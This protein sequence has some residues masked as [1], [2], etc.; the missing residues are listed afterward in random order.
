[1]ILGVDFLDEHALVLDFTNTSVG[2]HPASQAATAAQILLIYEAVRKLEARA[3]VIT[4]TAVQPGADIVDKYA[5]PMYQKPA[6]IELPECP[7][8]GLLAVVQKYQD[9]FQTTPG[10]TEAAYHFVPT[11]SNPV[12]IPL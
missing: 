12:K 5:V 4:D 6:S 8:P 11:S 9:L 1:M 2:V 7:K 10:V 3:C